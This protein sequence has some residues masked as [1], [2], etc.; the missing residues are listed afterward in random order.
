ML[1]NVGNKFGVQSEEK[2]S[3]K[4]FK[5]EYRWKYTSRDNNKISMLVVYRKI[6]HNIIELTYLLD[7]VQHMFLETSIHYILC[8]QGDF[9]SLQLSCMQNIHDTVNDMV[10][11]L[12]QHLW[13]S[14]RMGQI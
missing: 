8:S 13:T 1:V 2:K 12:G 14:Q 3:F 10:D 11:R 6:G 4:Y 9:C 5:T 7:I